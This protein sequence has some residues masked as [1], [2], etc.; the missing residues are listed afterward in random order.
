MSS[1]YEKSRKSLE[2]LLAWYEQEVTEHN[3]NEATT[4]LQLI[5]RLLFECLGWRKKDCKAEEPYG[6]E[7]TDY[8]LFCPYRALIVEAKKE[9]IYFELPAG[10]TK[11]DY[12]LKSL[13]KDNKQISNAIKQ[14]IGY[15]QSRGTPLGAVCN[16]HQ[17]ICCIASRDDGR[18]PLESKAIVFTSMKEMY[19]KFLTLWKYLS[20]PGLEERN[21]QRYILG[22]DRSALPDK[23][24]RVISSYSRIK[25]RNPLQIDLQTVGEVVIEDVNRAREIEADFIMDC[26]CPS[27]ALSQYALVS[28]SILENRY[29]ALSISNSKE[30][31]FVPA[32][33]KKGVTE[34]LFTEGISRRPI[35][36]L[37]DVGVGKTMF[38]RYLMKVEIADVLEDS[39]VLYLDLGTGASLS[40]DVKSFFLTDIEMQLF[41]NYEIDIKERNFVRGVYYG[42][43]KKFEQSI[44]SD[45]KQIDP[46]TYKKQEIK[47]LEG[48]LFKQDHHLENCLT[49]I[50]KGWKKQIV[51]FID[52]AD[53]RDPEVQQQAFIIAQDVAANWPVTVFLSIRPET[54]HRSKKSGALS[55]YHPKAFTIS[56]PRV[57]EVLKKRLQFALK[58]AKG[59]IELKLLSDIS[60]KLQTLQEY[61]TI[62]LY[63]FDQNTE[64]VEF[65]DNI[66]SGNIRLALEFVTTFIGSGHINTQKILDT[67]AKCAPGEHYIV[68][69][70]K[71]IK[72]IIYGDNEYYDPQTSHMANVFDISTTDG[73]EHFLLPILIEYISRAAS[74]AEVE[75]FVNMSSIY[76]YSQQIGFTPT[77]AESALV[78]ALHKNLLETSPRLGPNEQGLTSHS[79]RATTVGIY[80]IKKLL[81]Y[82]VYID[83]IIT[84]T[85]ILD[86]DIRNQITNV[87]K[88]NGRLNRALKFCD[89]LDTQWA[90]IKSKVAGFSWPEISKDIRNDIK[91]IVARITK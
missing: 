21:L 77:Q 84:D 40:S 57:D 30:P 49:H 65:I 6:K 18:P 16:G 66:C 85:P 52:N 71:F 36:L 45:L 27:G 38:I 61:L 87:A 44:Y 14:V 4:R 34:E 15:C 8:S 10:Y 5:D 25:H 24:S 7:Y 42:E 9:G 81:R 47:F 55:G 80:H 58:V 35:I 1:N 89:Y 50:Y 83:A 70:Y 41:K 31:A 19:D 11:L 91:N 53:Q 62:L 78:R 39:I 33:T 76:E 73:K 22:P 64:L 43:L 51:L 32:T 59:D 48:K 13:C 23:L 54:F 56:P 88:I 82:F 26:F 29:A 2:N 20:K 37:G 63:S 90:L 79:Y 86:D 74:F 69:P 67:E 68:P 75:G 12:S 3:R 17:L 46:A 60:V 28:K 72:A